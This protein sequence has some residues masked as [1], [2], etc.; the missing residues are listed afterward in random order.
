MGLVS[1]LP[2]QVGGVATLAEW[3]LGHEREIGCRYDAFDLRRPP[4]GEAGGRFRVASTARQAVLLG[5]FVRWLR[6]APPLVHFCVSSTPT[7]LTRDLLFVSL[8]RLARRRTIAQIQVIDEPNPL[9]SLALRLLARL[10]VERVT[11]APSASA[12]LARMGVGSRPVFNPLRIEPGAPPEHPPVDTL[13]VLFVGTYGERKGC[14]ELLDAL[15]EVRAGG[16]DVTLRF[17]GKEEHRGEEDLLRQRVRERDLDDAVEFA[18]VASPDELPALYAAADVFCLPSRREGLPLALLEAMAFGLPIVA[19]P[20]GGIADVVEDGVSGL[21]VAPGDV[22]GLAAT[23]ARLAEDV[24]LRRELGE[25]AR[26]R[27]RE[28][29]DAD[30]IAAQWRELYGAYAP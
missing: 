15:A 22:R 11:V 20:V 26:K 21:L 3:L 29:F 17:V 9:R 7:G 5:R 2:P 23:L 4:G 13:C 30:T 18:G 25:G 16:A 12:L 10:T 14:P 8:L 28:L 27:A 24:E 1:P 6:T 19:T